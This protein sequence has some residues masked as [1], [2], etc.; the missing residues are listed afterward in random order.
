MKRLRT[1]ILILLFTILLTSCNKPAG[2]TV[3]NEKKTEK[4]L[5]NKE[6]GNEEDKKNEEGDKPAELK[7]ELS[8]SEDYKACGF[9]FYGKIEDA[10][11]KFNVESIKNPK[12]F[13]GKI[14]QLI[15]TYKNDE[16]ILLN[17][18]N[19]N[20]EFASFDLK[21]NKYRTL[22]KIDEKYRVR[23]MYLHDDYLIYIISES[24]DDRDEN[25]ELRFYNIKSGEDVRIRLY[26]KAATWRFNEILYHENKVYFDDL[27]ELKNDDFTVC[28]YS[29]DIASGKTEKI[30]ENA[31]NPQ[32]YK[33]R[34]IA[35]FSEEK[36]K[37]EHIKY[38]DN[39]EDIYKFDGNASKFFAY[40]DSLIAFVYE[41]TDKDKK[42]YFNY[43]KDLVSGEVYV[44]ST[45]QE[46]MTVNGISDGII[47]LQMMNVHS[48]IAIDI[49]SKTVYSFEKEGRGYYF[50]NKFDEKKGIMMIMSYEDKKMV[51]KNFLISE[52]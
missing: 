51:Q 22:L 28:I 41:Y 25:S 1:G 4:N 12:E 11:E 10:S 33:G 6:A 48:P 40:K 21:T 3:D 14:Q 49:K 19:N 16:I 31:Q 2:T 34:L 13:D 32:L 20:E 30:A 35:L 29:Y 27:L 15:G 45:D 8:T 52:K 36:G 47:Y 5:D 38:I 24:K 43:L 39:K 9:D 23:R 26:D 46:L 18:Y 17:I 50:L 37:Y 7:K 44:K 42:F